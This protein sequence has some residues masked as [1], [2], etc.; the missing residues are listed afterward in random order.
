MF[1]SKC[2]LVGIAG[3]FLANSIL[4]SPILTTPIPAN[5]SPVSIKELTSTVTVY[6]C[7]SG[8]TGADVDAGIHPPHPTKPIGQPSTSTVHVPRGTNLAPARHP[9]I[10]P[11]DL[12]NLLTNS[13]VE[14]FYNDPVPLTS[15]SLHH[16]ES[17]YRT[18]S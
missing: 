17:I 12:A 8:A 7:G 6:G 11:R 18:E 10:D 14:L 9:D 3:I 4:A 16:P 2:F 13:S 5:G 1:S 15:S